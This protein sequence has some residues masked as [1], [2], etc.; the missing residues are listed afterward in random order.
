MISFDSL[1][2]I[3]YYDPVE[4]WKTCFNPNNKIFLSWFI[5]FSIKRKKHN[6]EAKQMWACSHPPCRTIYLNICLHTI[7]ITL[8]YIHIRNI[9][10]YSVYFTFT[11][12]PLFLFI[13]RVHINIELYLI[14]VLHMFHQNFNATFHVHV[15]CPI[16]SVRCPWCVM[17]MSLVLSQCRSCLRMDRIFC[18]CLWS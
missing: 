4:F 13:I 11:L 8:E 3:L 5:Y 7:T 16:S 12:T 10:I 14:H 9:L 17:S 2:W 1:N 18:M 15:S 6:L